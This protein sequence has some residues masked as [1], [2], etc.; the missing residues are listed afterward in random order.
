MSDHETP[1]GW[2]DAMYLEAAR[3]T[4]SRV[5]ATIDRW[6]DGD[7]IDIDSARSGGMLTL[8]LP[9]RSQLIINTQPPL[10][11]LWLAARSGGYHF[12]Y[13]G[14]QR[15]LDTRTGEDFF[16]VLSACASEQSGRALNF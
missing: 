10:H 1:S 6:L 16:T 8:T 15:W 4:L 12:K 11:E 5:E 3:T 7:V 14:E 2:P 13:A 9:D